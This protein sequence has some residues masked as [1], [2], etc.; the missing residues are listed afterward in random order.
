MATGR[1]AV[2]YLD[3][4]R[5]AARVLSG[6]EEAFRQFFDDN[7][8]RLYRFA[9]TRLKND[10]D[11][12]EDIVQLSFSKA[13][14]KLHT[15]KAE[16]QLHTWLCAICR[17][18]IGDWYRKQGR[19]EE[20]IVLVEDQPAL[21]AVIDSFRAPAIDDPVLSFQRT[22]AT[23]LIQVALDRL[24]PNYGNALEWKYVEG[25]SSKE[26]AERLNIGVEAAQSLLA[27]AKRAFA[28][29]YGAL[30]GASNESASRG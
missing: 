14:A 2:V 27:R 6:D 16:S 10:I 9:L 23:R 11:A 8:D 20:R 4:K 1:K 13:L 19:Y 7:Y 24:P 17:N 26:I 12:A 21:Q 22:E 25:Y 15:Y 30:A 28:D 5:L 3:D 29:V 18:D